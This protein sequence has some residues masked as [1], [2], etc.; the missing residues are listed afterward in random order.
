MLEEE[1]S[2]HLQGLYR[3]WGADIF[4]FVPNEYQ[5]ME[6]GDAFTYRWYIERLSLKLNLKVQLCPRLRFAN[7]N[8]RFE[9]EFGACPYLSVYLFEC[10]ISRMLYMVLHVFKRWTIKCRDE[11]WTTYYI[12]ENANKKMSIYYVFNLF[13]NYMGLTCR[14]GMR[15][16]STHTENIRIICLVITGKVTCALDTRKVGLCGGARVSSWYIQCFV[17]LN[18]R[19]LLLALLVYTH[20][21][22]IKQLR[23]GPAI[24]SM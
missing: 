23:Y 3:I 5:Y 24:Y 10:Q 17:I 14:K 20:L 21:P 15:N 8:H 11:N 9:E 18:Q 12:V 7:S 1:K 22:G 4:L 2:V 19:S 6:I 13:R 16:S